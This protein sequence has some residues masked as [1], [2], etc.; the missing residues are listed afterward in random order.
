MSHVCH[1]FT[2]LLTIS[3]GVLFRSWLQFVE[4]ALKNFFKTFGFFCILK[5]DSQLLHLDLLIREVAG[6]VAPGPVRVGH[7]SQLH[8]WSH[9]VVGTQLQDLNKKQ[10]GK[11]NQYMVKAKETRQMI[12]KK[13]KMGWEHFTHSWVDVSKTE[14]RRILIMSFSLSNMP[15]MK[16]FW[17]NASEIRWL[18]SL[19]IYL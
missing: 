17:P 14:A 2:L 9:I 3:A 11:M 10:N 16:S 4:T 1:F 8:L 13:M 18:G 6:C 12:L 7:R 19:K 5:L 15:I